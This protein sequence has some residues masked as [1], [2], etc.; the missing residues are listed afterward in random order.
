MTN[1]LN[2]QA[3]TKQEGRRYRLRCL[4]SPRM[5]I[6][7]VRQSQRNAQSGGELNRDK[8]G[9]TRMNMMARISACTRL[10]QPKIPKHSSMPSLR[11]Y[12]FQQKSSNT[13]TRTSLT[14]VG[15]SSTR[16]EQMHTRRLGSATRTERVQSAAAGERPRRSLRCVLRSK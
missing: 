3:Q 7:G 15:L 8:I 16:T 2:G 6:T 11:V 5:E 10:S 13:W 12:S 1:A 14:N 9:S 4:G